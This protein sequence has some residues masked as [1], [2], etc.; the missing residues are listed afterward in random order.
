ME[1]ELKKIIAFIQKNVGRMNIV[2]GLSGGLDSSVCAF[3]SHRA[4]SKEKIYALIMPSQFTPKQDIKNAQLVANIL[5]IEN[6]IINIDSIIKVYTEQT[7][8]IKTKKTLGN[9]QARV[10]M[11]LLYAMANS[12]NSLVMGTGNKSEIMTGYST[13]HGDG[14]V[15]LLPIGDLYK[16]QV[17]E[18]AKFINVPEGII[19]AKPTA[20]LWNNQYD[21]DELK[22]TYSKL[23]KILSCLEAKKSTKHFNSHDVD[24][25]QQYI[26]LSEHKRKKIP[27]CKI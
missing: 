17:R 13:K 22:I 10:R 14:G 21:E 18:L 25:V 16:T 7:D 20:G 15:D 2:I 27:I 24:L 11:S 4:I 5:E 26:K 3:L 19:N 9:L 12:S 8:F 1:K 23:D 6:E